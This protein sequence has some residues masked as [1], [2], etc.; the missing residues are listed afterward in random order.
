VYE[1]FIIEA[2][3]T[4][5]QEW[6]ERYGFRGIGTYIGRE[7]VK[8]VLK[9]SS[10]AVELKEGDVVVINDLTALVGDPLR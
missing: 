1:A 2:P 3:S 5:S 8:L 6:V 9:T 10:S 7:E 4:A